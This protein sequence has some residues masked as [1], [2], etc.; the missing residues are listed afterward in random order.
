LEEKFAREHK[1]NTPNIDIA[2]NRFIPAT[3]ELKI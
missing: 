1:E 3:D 2:V